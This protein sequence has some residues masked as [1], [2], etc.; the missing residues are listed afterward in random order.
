MHSMRSDSDMRSGDAMRAD[1]L[2]AAVVSAL[3][4]ALGR[5]GLLTDASECLAYGYDNS[6][7]QG[8]PQAVALPTT[9]E[10][11]QAL[12]RIAREAKLPIVARGRG[13]TRAAT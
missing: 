8:M 1:D 3:S 2:P 5:D 11:V 9:T 13:T 4:N 12:V 10:H 7:R 6:R